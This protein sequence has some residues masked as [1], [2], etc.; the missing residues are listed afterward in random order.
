MA[1]APVVWLLR[2]VYRKDKYDT[3][4]IFKV[5]LNEQEATLPI[6]TD[7]APY[8]HWRDFRR[9]YLKKLD[10]YDKVRLQRH[11]LTKGQRNSQ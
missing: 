8:Y 10:D 9:Y 11:T 6:E 7:I 3:D 1:V 2:Y 5:L 4:V